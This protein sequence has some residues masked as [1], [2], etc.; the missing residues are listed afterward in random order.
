SQTGERVVEVVLILRHRPD[1][2]PL[3][4]QF[5]T[6]TVDEG[7]RRLSRRQPEIGLILRPRAETQ[8]LRGGEMGGGNGNPGTECRAE[9]RVARR[10]DDCPGDLEAGL[11]ER[12]RVSHPRAER[13]EQRRVDYGP[14][15][16]L[17]IRPGGR[18]IRDDSAVK[19]V[20]RLDR[21]DLYEPRA[22]RAWYEC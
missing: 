17:Q 4:P 15:A 18:W 22:G 14:T 8:Q 3:G 10:A 5:G 7:L 1:L 20:T 13:G 6:V 2:N 12:E 11:A 9:A 19:G 16:S 21:F